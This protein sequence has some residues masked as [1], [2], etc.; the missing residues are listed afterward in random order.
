MQYQSTVICEDV[1][2]LGLFTKKYQIGRTFICEDW[3]D[4]L[5]QTNGLIP[6]IKSGLYSSKVFEQAMKDNSW[7]AISG[8]IMS[9]YES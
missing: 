3:K 9:I 1:G 6:E 2:E 8:R 7:E 5:N 4:F